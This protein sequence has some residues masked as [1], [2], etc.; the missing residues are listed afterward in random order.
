M[1]KQWTD[2]T[3]EE[4]REERFKRWLSPDIKFASPEAERLHKERVTR[5]IK[6][7]KLEKPDRVPVMIPAQFLPSVYAGYN[8]GTVMHDYGKLKEAWLK[9][10]N[11]F[12]MDSFLPPSLVLPARV[13]EMIDFKLIKWPRRGLPDDAPSYQFVEGE[14][15]KAEEYD[16]LINDPADYLLRYFMPRSAGA[17]KAFS[18]FA[19]LTPFVAIP[20]GYVAQFADP[21]IRKAYETLFEAGQEAMKWAMAIGEMSQIGLAAGYPNIWGGMSQAPFD[22]VGD[23]LRG[24][25]GIM[26]DMFQRP[27]KLK[28]AMARLTPVAISEAVSS[29]NASGCPIIFIPLHKGTG[30]FMSNKQFEEFYWPTLKEVMMGLINEGCIPLPFAEG[31]YEPRLEIIKD[32]PRSSTIWFFEH[33]DM[34]K[35][36]K[37]LGHTCIAGNV[38]VTVMVTGQPGEVKERCRKLIEICAPGSGYILTAGA[39]MDIGNPDNLRAMMAAA[40]EYGVY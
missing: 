34:A 16:A 28:E 21:E 27:D 31:D 10:L 12:E 37:I 18:K 25:R 7:I 5:F 29:A 39:F 14:Y 8:L 40:K 35:A 33:M 17:F 20:V 19:P 4:K 26:M 36:K 30:G 38:P 32:M 22:M 13:L 1:E 15:M 23:F 3:W 6:A 11:D 2:M 9:F 24:T